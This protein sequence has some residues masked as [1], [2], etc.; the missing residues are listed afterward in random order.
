MK[1]RKIWEN[2]H[3]E[4]RE[5]GQYERLD[6][7]ERERERRS[8]VKAIDRS[9]WRR[10]RA[11]RR[12]TSQGGCGWVL[13]FVCDQKVRRRH[14]GVKEEDLGGWRGMTP[15]PRRLLRGGDST[16]DAGK[17][18]STNIFTRLDVTAKALIP[19]PLHAFR[20]KHGC[21]KIR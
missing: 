13:P 12:I 8:R 9:R 6:E 1:R 14:E 21:R 10:E 5:G 17:I 15:P 2:M 11:V 19:D 16:Q 3:G 20:V 4:G 18:T 7:C